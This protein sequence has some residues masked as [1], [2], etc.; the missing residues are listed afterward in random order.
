[1]TYN[2]YKFVMVIKTESDEGTEV[3]KEVRL[4]QEQ[5]EMILTKQQFKFLRTNAW[6]TSGL[7]LLERRSYSMNELKRRFDTV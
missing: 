4:S 1:M 7:M 5:V 6:V 2:D 3:T